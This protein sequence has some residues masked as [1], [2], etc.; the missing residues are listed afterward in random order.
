EVSID[1][2][3]G[4]PDAA[5]GSRTAAEQPAGEPAGARRADDLVQRLTRQEL[6]RRRG[7]DCPALERGLRRLGRRLRHAFPQRTP[8]D[9]AGDAAGG[10]LAGLTQEPPADAERH[11][12]LEG[13]GQWRDDRCGPARRLRVD[14]LA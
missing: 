13:S 9:L 2:G 12:R 8:G 3:D 1:G 4:R 7:R 10:L 6:L 5:Y 14:A 11:E